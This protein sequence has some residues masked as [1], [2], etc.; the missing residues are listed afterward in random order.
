MAAE[1]T[2]SAVCDASSLAIAASR[3]QGCPASFILAGV[4]RQLARRF[5]TGVHVCKSKLDSL[6][7][8]NTLAEGFSLLRVFQCIVERGLGHSERLCSDSDAPGLQARQ[9]NA[10]SFTL[11][12]D[13][14]FKR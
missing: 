12:P 13:A 10:I 7:V 14:I 4:E 5:Q 3:K 8:K 1:Q 9:R 11:S 6:V 2:R